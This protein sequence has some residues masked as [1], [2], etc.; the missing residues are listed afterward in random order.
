MFRGGRVDARGTGIASGLGYEKGGRVGYEMGGN[1]RGGI[2]NLPG[3]YNK[4][5]QQRLDA[6]KSE[7]EKTKLAQPGVRIYDEPY[8][9][10]EWEDFKDTM[11][12][13]G[14]HQT[15]LDY[16]MGLIP[17]HSIEE[18]NI[19]KFIEGGK[20]ADMYEMFKAGELPGSTVN[21]GTKKAEQMK[22]DPSLFPDE[23]AEVKSD[24]ET[25]EEFEERIRRENAEELQAIIDAQLSKG[26]PEEEIEKNKKIFQKAYGSGVA[27]DAS[28]MALGL[29]SRMLEP[30]A[31]VK[32]GFGKFFGDEQKRPSE[33]KKYKDA[34]TTAAINAFLTG[35]KT[36]AEVDAY[37]QKALAGERTKYK[38]AQEYSSSMPWSARRDEKGE[39]FT[40]DTKFF[41]SK[42]PKYL[43]DIKVPYTSIE[44][45]DEEDVKITGDKAQENVGKVFVDVDSDVFFIVEMGPDG[46]IRKRYLQNI[47]G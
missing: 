9:Q 30:E 22:A 45:A 20:E 31:T 28:A 7:L 24:E 46:K 6:W 15:D 16:G 43:S 2:V 32:S 38:V 29:A 35:E 3:G 34:A 13:G 18:K 41:K 42:L 1:I 12:T 26:T 4:T 21:Y 39:K 33:R 5:A 8:I 17:P 23:V 10:S 44:F 36:M 40:T 27:D 37:M 47:L 11:Y 14:I 25:R 19:M